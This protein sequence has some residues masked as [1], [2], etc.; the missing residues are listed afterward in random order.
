M[1]VELVEKHFGKIYF[2]IAGLVLFTLFDSISI[3]LRRNT[4]NWTESLLQFS[5]AFMMFACGFLYSHLKVEDKYVKKYS[6]SSWILFP[7]SNHVSNFYLK[8][9]NN[10]GFILS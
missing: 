4:F 10:M 6:I 1:G 5:M 9:R 7:Y 2:I 8:Y 3:D